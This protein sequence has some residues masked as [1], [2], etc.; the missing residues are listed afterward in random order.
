[1][2]KTKTPKE[3]NKIYPETPHLIFCEGVDAYYFLIWFLD[4]VKR[5]SEEFNAFRVYDF[6]GIAELRQYLH[7]IAQTDHFN[8]C[9]QSI[10]IIRDAETNAEEACQSVKDALRDGGFAVPESPC[11]RA[12]NSNV[13]Y[14]QIGTGFVLF[15]SCDA[16]PQNGTLED[17]C[18][19]LLANENAESVLSNVDAVLTNYQFRRPHKNRL[20]TY[21]SLTDEFVSLKIGEAAR[22]NAFSLQDTKIEALRAFLL[23]MKRG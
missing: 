17:L 18:L 3:R 2:P 8:E 23:K 1:M 11:C 5:E 15:P 21:F 9:V 10:S 12:C 20:H 16:E 14:R 6:G 19:A 22:A 4:I 7:A 13:Q